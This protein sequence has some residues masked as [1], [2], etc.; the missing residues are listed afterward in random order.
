MEKYDLI[1]A[2]DC[3]IDFIKQIKLKTIFDF[4]QN[5]SSK[6]KDIIITYVEGYVDKFLHE[7]KIISINGKKCGIFLVRNFE[8]GYLLD[9]LYLLPEFRNK[10]IGSDIIKKAKG[11]YNKISLWVYKENLKAISLYKRMGFLISLDEKERFLMT[12]TKK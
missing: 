12:Y 5:M 1:S 3:D 6:E 8:D 7:Y 9:E 10:G 2:K 11:K 4:A